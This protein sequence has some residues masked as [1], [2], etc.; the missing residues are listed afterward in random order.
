MNLS[1]INLLKDHRI[2]GLS[3]SAIVTS[4]VVTPTPAKLQAIHDDILRI[5]RSVYP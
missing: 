4:Y 2:N 5:Y 1:N 3:V